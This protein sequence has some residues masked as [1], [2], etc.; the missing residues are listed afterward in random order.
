MKSGQQYNKPADVKVIFNV[1]RYDFTSM[2]ASL[3]IELQV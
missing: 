2:L 3:D 1:G